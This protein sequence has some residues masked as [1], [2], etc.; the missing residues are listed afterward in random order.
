MSIEIPQDPAVPRASDTR[1]W[2]P[3]T[4]P[5]TTHID[6]TDLAP[7]ESPTVSPGAGQAAALAALQRASAWALHEEIGR[8]RERGVSWR[9]LAATLDM[10]A[11]TLLRHYR[12]GR[13]IVVIGQKSPDDVYYRKDIG[14]QLV[15]SLTP[16]LRTVV[17]D[18]LN[19]DP[20]VAADRFLGRTSE[21]SEMTALLGRS[22]A[23]TLTG[24]AGVG[25]TR[26]ALEYISQMSQFGA[27]PVRWVDL[28]P[29][30]DAAMV[31]PAVAAAVHEG[32]PPAALVEDLVAERYGRTKAVI[33][34][35]NC[36]H[37]AAACAA[38]V[39]RL[40]ARCPHLHILATSREPLQIRGEVILTLSP[41]S[42]VAD[43]PQQDLAVQLFVDRARTA[44]PSFR[45]TPE[46]AATI[47]DVCTQLDGLPLAIELAARQAAVLPPEQLLRGMERR[48]D[49]LVNHLRGAPDRHQSLRQAI[50]WSHNLLTA[51]E[52]R[53]FR[54]L[55]YA[56]G[57]FDESLAHALCHTS[58]PQP[59]DPWPLLSA[60]AAKSLL[61]PDAPGRFRILE[62][63]RL[64]GTEQLRAGSEEGT[65]RARFLAWAGD[66]AKTMLL[67]T[68]N[69][70]VIGTV[71]A[72]RHHLQH[73]VQAAE[74]ANDHR[75]PLM[76]AALAA[77]WIRLGNHQPARDLTRRLLL[78]EPPAAGRAH[79]E[80]SRSLACRMA[81]DFDEARS[82]ARTALD[83][84]R[85]LQHP[86]LTVRSLSALSRAHSAMGAHGKAV[87]ASRDQVAL[88][89]TTHQ[90]FALATA[91]NDLAWVILPAGLTDEA[92]EYIDEAL[93]LLD[94]AS[95]P[96]AFST[97][98][99]TAGS[100]AMAAGHYEEAE[101]HFGASLTRTSA[102]TDTTLYNLEGLAVTALATGDSSRGLHLAAA[103]AAARSHTQVMAT[104]WWA[105]MV[106][107][108]TNRAGAPRYPARQGRTPGGNLE[109]AVHYALS[110]QSPQSAAAGTH[111]TQRE[112]QV[113]ELV[114]QGLTDQ[115]VAARL[116]ISPRTASNYAASIRTKLGLATR[117]HIA[118]WVTSQ[119]PPTE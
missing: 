16:I 62:S 114:A 3:D 115:Q 78:Q 119:R 108:F 1:A 18:G 88:L 27:S 26:L 76:G 57:S 19:G 59:P 45:L 100:I 20:P 66:L 32:R 118:T 113:A 42:A 25:K 29:L 9:D 104:P 30:S 93:T 28:G 94:P 112:Y 50:Q 89:R 109:D 23:L 24:P 58:R 83:I 61:M 35:D 47:A 51:E 44:D 22:R 72:E 48:L 110:C 31:E 34:L 99:H 7:G 107:D 85:D 60:L 11:M 96:E 63:L 65:A 36:E 13:G 95:S 86:A 39:Q 54:A 52:R 53:A 69:H 71:D 12:A 75:L 67:S 77:C 5:A 41:L 2:E 82:T 101:A 106:A 37:L 10:S 4:P 90:T 92:G 116:Q 73:A 103:A 15:H 97:A 111:L 46:L 117:I 98:Q 40:L 55:C 49:L 33:V 64:F 79:L 38:M 68:A 91:L 21:L 56:P 8:A 102:N 17:D 105:D 74:E 87:A 81:G 80:C 6:T 84:A 70:E 43:P 14:R